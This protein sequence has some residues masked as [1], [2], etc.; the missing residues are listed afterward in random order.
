MD[1][2][3]CLTCRTALLAPLLLALLGACSVGPD[4]R[5]PDPAAELPTRFKEDWKTAQPQDQALPP[6]WWRL[7]NFNVALAAAQGA[8]STTSFMWQPILPPE[9]EPSP[10]T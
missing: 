4:Y 1:A 10:G 8:M 2:K 5:R 7:A 6:E 3:R 9:P